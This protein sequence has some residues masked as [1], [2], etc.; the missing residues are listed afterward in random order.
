ML[1]VWFC[2]DGTLIFVVKV[3]GIVKIAYNTI[4]YLMTVVK[5]NSSAQKK[6]LVSDLILPIYA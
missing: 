1:T 4:L 6:F 5:K 2:L 3:P